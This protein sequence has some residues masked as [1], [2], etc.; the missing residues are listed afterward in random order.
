[1]DVFLDRL[2]FSVHSSKVIALCE[3]GKV[4]GFITPVICSNLYY[5]LRRT[6]EHKKVIEQLNQLL[7]FTDVVLMDKQT[8]VHAL[9]S[10]FKD[11]EDAL[12]NC[13]AEKSESIEIILTRNT[14]DYSRSNLVVLTPEL[15]LKMLKSI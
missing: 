8:V 4:K 7:S 10:E 13:A 15:F 9:N 12:Q 2:P 14:K 5:L 11:F 1:M 3:V 6:A